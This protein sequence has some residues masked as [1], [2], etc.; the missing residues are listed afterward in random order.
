[1]SEA[2]AQW[3]EAL[4]INPTYTEALF[5]MGLAYS[6]MGDLDQALAAYQ[7]LLRI[8][9]GMLQ[10]HASLASL[11]EKRGDLSQA[12]AEFRQA[13]QI[14]TNQGNEA[15]RE[16]MEREIARLSSPV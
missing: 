1:M 6:E 7:Q 16:Q 15:Y 12:L 9:S 14:A 10:A 11:Y 8:D 2:V 13:A 3:R 4:R 5:N